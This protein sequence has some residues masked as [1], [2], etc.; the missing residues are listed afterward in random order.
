MLLYLFIILLAQQSYPKLKQFLNWI[1]PQIHHKNSVHGKFEHFPYCILIFR[2]PKIYKLYHPKFLYQKFTRFFK[3]NPDLLICHVD[4]SKDICN[5]KH[6]M[7]MKVPFSKYLS[8]SDQIKIKPTQGF[9][10]VYGIPKLHKKYS[11]VQLP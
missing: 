2:I 1:S 11:I 6:F 3:Q 5:L 10:R 9:K 4:K 7:A 8:R